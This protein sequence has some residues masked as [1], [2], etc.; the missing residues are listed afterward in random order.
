M[1]AV[2]HDMLILADLNSSDHGA[3]EADM[4]AFKAG[5]DIVTTQGITTHAAT[6]CVQHEAVKWH[7]RAEVVHT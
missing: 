7:K 3:Y 5:L 6:P 1:H 2:F 4:M